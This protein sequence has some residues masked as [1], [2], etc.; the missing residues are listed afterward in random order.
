MYIIRGPNSYEFKTKQKFE[1]RD[2]VV[3]PTTPEYLWRSKVPITFDRSDHLDHV[4][5]LGDYPL[6]LNPTV[7]DARL[8]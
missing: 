8:H 4:P 7:G 2:H 3:Q 1:A 6:I 5:L